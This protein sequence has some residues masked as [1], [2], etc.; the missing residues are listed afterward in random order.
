MRLYI[1]LLFLIQAF[2]SCSQE[3]LKIPDE[4]TFVQ[5]V[6]IASDTSENL[7]SIYG[8]NEKLIR[9]FHQKLSKSGL[10]D[11][12]KASILNLNYP[13]LYMIDRLDKANSNEL[14]AAM[15]N[16]FNDCYTQE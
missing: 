11:T 2:S 4:N 14:R 13:P 6:L 1:V 3:P 8:K 16:Y 5:N 9:C 15:C 12:V 10:V 7:V